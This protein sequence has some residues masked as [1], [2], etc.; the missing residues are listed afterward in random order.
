MSPSEIRANPMR[1]LPTCRSLVVLPVALVL[2]A[3]S[4]LFAG[5]A[6]GEARTRVVFETTHGT[7]LVELDR[8]ATPATVDNFLAY[9]RD[10]HYRGTIFHRV[11]AGFMIQGGGYTPDYRR[12]PTRAPIRNEAHRAGGNERG[13]IAMARTSDPHSATNQF[14]INVADNDFLNHRG[15]TPRG[16]GYAVFGRV[17]EGMDAV[18][19]IAG[20]PTGTGGPFPGDVPTEAVVIREIR[21]HPV[22]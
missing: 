12:S 2:L 19:R 3:F 22:E 4:A 18:D 16:W 20:L 5:A 13:T 17:V 21:I 11:I 15:R 8:T 14:F 1:T 7:F 10:G 9:V 6:K